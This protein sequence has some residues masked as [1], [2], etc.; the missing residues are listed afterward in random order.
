[1]DEVEWEGK[2]KEDEAVG[3]EL[4]LEE[5]EDGLVGEGEGAIWRAE[6]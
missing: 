6:G 1:M 4:L 2:V 5:G 3:G